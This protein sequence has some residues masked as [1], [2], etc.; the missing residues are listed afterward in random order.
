MPQ[1]P[2]FTEDL[3]FISRLGDN[4]NTDDGLSAQALKEEFDKAPKV[5]QEFINN[6][7]IPSLNNYIMGNG[8]LQTSGGYMTGPIVMQ[9]NKVTK[10]GAPTADDDAAT[11][12][13]ADDVAANT[14]ETAYSANQTAETALDKANDAITAADAAANSASA[15]ANTANGALPKAGGTMTGALKTKGIVLTSGTDYGPTLPANPVEGQ[16]FFEVID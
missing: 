4:P 12:K 8:Y 6:Y 11:K 5:I 16:L 15:A 10:L 3:G 2:Q 9:E 7:I 14:L 1:I 13:Y